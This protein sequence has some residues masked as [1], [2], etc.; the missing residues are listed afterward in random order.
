VVAARVHDP[1]HA[2]SP[3]SVEDSGGAHDVRCADLGEWCLAGDAGEVYDRVDVANG[4]FH[5]IGIP[6]VG[7]DGILTGRN[8]VG[9]LD[10]E[11]PQPPAEMGK[12]A[13]QIS[14]DPAGRAGDQD[15]AHGGQ[16]PAKQA[17]AL[18]VTARS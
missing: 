16:H 14:S 1:G 18:A 6:D 7:D 12:T 8:V 13:P 17:G 4:R 9:L 10:I 15:H 2:R 5:R 11:E 3:G